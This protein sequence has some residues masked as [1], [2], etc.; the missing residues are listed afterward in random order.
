M[1]DDMSITPKQ[2]MHGAEMAID[3]IRQDP[4]LRGHITKANKEPVRVPVGYLTEED[5]KHMDITWYHSGIQT[6]LPNPFSKSLTLYT[7]D[8]TITAINNETPEEHDGVKAV[9]SDA[10][11]RAGHPRLEYWTP[12][13]QDQ[14]DKHVYELAKHW[15]TG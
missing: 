14:T 5:L 10:A 4:F 15:R 3:F 11:V 1:S 13:T 9:T 12:L 6:P 2:R 7:L 8:S